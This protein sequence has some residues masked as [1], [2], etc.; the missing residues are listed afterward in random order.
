MTNSKGFEANA[1]RN[2]ANPEITAF[3]LIERSSF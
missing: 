2:P 1:P 3:S